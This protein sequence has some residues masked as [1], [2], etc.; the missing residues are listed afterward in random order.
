MSDVAGVGVHNNNSNNNISYHNTRHHR[1]VPTTWDNA[2]TSAY[3]HH[4]RHRRHVASA[5]AHATEA[6]S[7]LLSIALYIILLR[8]KWPGEYVC[9]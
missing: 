6:N 5:T 8:I 9:S 7:G 3:L 4:H 1:H 2:A